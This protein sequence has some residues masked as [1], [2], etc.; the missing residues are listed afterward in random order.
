MPTSTVVPLGPTTS[1]PGAPR[2]RV[3][4][5]VALA[6]L[7]LAGVGVATVVLTAPSPGPD[8]G[9]ASPSLRTAPAFSLPAVRAGAD[10]VALP[11]GR[12]VVVNFF[13]SWCVPCREELPLL[14]QA[15]RRLAGSV[16]V[17][18]VD[19]GDS[20]GA[21]TELLDQTGVTFPT[22]FDPGR[23]VASRYRLQG[24]PTTVFVDAGGRVRAVAM[25]KLTEAELDRHLAGL[26]G[27]GGVGTSGTDE[28]G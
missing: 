18:G 11:P 9:A 3:G 14:E 5:P 10:P 23:K 16:D 1:P 24:M 19:V 2:A 20:R 22:G 13:A 8:G 27:S 25:G 17:V 28:K 15:S 26:G 6:A 7:A 4:L 12:P 21:A